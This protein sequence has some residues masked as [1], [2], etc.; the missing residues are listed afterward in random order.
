[1]KRLVLVLFIAVLSMGSA[2]SQPDQRNPAERNQREIDNLTTELGLSKD[3]VNKITP[4]VV[5][6]QN[7]QGLAIAKMREAGGNFDR[8]KMR[9]MRL[10]MITETD[11]KLKGIISAEQAVKLDAF[12]K[13]QAEE[14]KKKMEQRN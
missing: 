5:E 1:M 11:Q 6:A 3:Q 8:D 2:F 14:R 10:K 7:K 13:K 12:R 4:L 9:E